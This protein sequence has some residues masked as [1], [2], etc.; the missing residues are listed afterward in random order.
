MGYRP[1]GLPGP[2]WRAVQVPDDAPPGEYRI[3]KRVGGRASTV[4]VVIR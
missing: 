4:P 1:V 2:A 3:V